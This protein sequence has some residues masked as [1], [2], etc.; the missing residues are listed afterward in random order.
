[1]RPKN[2]FSEV[3][4]DFIKEHGCPSA[5][6][7]DNAKKEQ[8]EEIMKIHRELFIKDQFTEPYNSQQNPVELRAIKY[9]KMHSHT[10]LD[11]TEAPESCWF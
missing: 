2:S 4:K 7:R 6:R 10:L 9:L 1:M 11:Q 8:N 3:Y 5:L